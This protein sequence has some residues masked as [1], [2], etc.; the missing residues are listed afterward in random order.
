MAINIGE[1]IKNNA[2][3]NNFNL[4]PN[5]DSKYGPYPTLGAALATIPKSERAIGL[6]VGIKTE[7]EIKEYW[8][9]G[10]VDEIHLVEKN[11]NSNLVDS[12]VISTSPPT[13]IA[14][15]GVEWIMIR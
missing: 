7:S 12:K 8:F 2:V 10:G 3:D 14:P 13:G 11:T 1:A 9:S 15:D 5:I 6:T 4:L